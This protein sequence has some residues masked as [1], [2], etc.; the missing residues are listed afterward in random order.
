M[1]E[2][3]FDILDIY[4]YPNC[5]VTQRHGALCCVQLVWLNV[6]YDTFSIVYYMYDCVLEYLLFIHLLKCN[7]W[8][9]FI[10]L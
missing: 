6:S 8:C 3:E 1:G 9:M 4:T 10:R 2:G 5:T 7:S